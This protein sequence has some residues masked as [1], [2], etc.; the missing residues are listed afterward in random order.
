MASPAE[1]T[2]PL[3]WPPLQVRERE[4]LEWRLAWITAIFGFL[5]YAN[6]L[7]NGYTLDDVS[8]IVENRDVQQGVTALPTIFRNSYR[9]GSSLSATD[10]LYRP[11]STAMF[12]IEWQ[13]WPAAPV[14]GHL[15]NVLFYSWSGFLLLRWLLQLFEQQGPLIPLVSSL[16]FMAHPVH[17]DVVAGVK[18]RD[19]VMSFFG[20]ILSLYWLLQYLRT[21]S[22]WRLWLAAGAYFLSLLSKETTITLVAVVPLMLWFFTTVSTRKIAG[23][24]GVYLAVAASYLLIRSRVIPGIIVDQ[25]SIPFLDNVLVDAPNIASRLASA[26]LILGR[27][28]YLLVFPTTLVCDYSYSATTIV[29]WR[30]P[31]VWL[32]LAGHL[33]LLAYAVRGCW[34][35]RES[36]SKDAIS[37]GILF[38]LM[39]LSLMSN[40]VLL[41]GAA[42]AER[43][44]YFPSVGFSLV[45]AS[46]LIKGVGTNPT[47]RHVSDVASLV[48]DHRR[49]F[50]LLSIVLAL[51]GART[52]TR[53]ADWRDNYTLYSTDVRKSPESFRLHFNLGL[54]LIKEK[55]AF[56]EDPAQQNVYLDDAIRALTEAI[57]IYPLYAEPFTQVG[58]VYHRQGDRQKAVQYYQH[59]LAINPQSTTTLSNLGSCYHELGQYRDAVAVLEKAH[60]LEPTNVAVLLNL[61]AAHGSL[62]DFDQ[63]IRCFRRVLELQPGNAPAQRYLDMT[64]QKKSKP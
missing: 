61:G 17:A 10:M 44:L 37:F 11:L 3:T 55:A 47:S 54:C 4:D 33:A 60:R 7:G 50:V 52:M 46:L 43:F 27:Y 39:T 18:G 19:E 21:G 63:A 16:L 36:A 35:G 13:L 49:L 26:L 9:H 23:L 64:Y 53:N 30:E 12:A 57:R 24:T 15:V 14:I 32:S 56:E 5:L 6:S 51:D 58:V 42:M 41:I 38:Y 8:S 2:A 45:L 22:S 25:Q 62:G 31:G 34:K 28:L 48:R 40:T 59:S 1:S 29:S 20:A